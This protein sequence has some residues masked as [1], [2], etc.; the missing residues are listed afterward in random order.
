MPIQLQ[1]RPTLGA[2]AIRR[3]TECYIAVDCAA[4][5]AGVGSST[6]AHFA[7]GDAMTI[8]MQHTPKWILT[9]GWEGQYPGSPCMLDATY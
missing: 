1:M 6:T 7:K 9:T 2:L 5:N 3:Y 8:D 4:C